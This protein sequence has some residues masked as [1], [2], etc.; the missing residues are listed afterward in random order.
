MHSAFFDVFVNLVCLITVICVGDRLL[1][2]KGLGLNLS[3]A[4]GIACAA[5]LFYFCAKVFHVS[6]YLSPFGRKVPWDRPN[7]FLIVF[8]LAAIVSL[9]LYVK[10]YVIGDRA[11]ITARMRSGGRHNK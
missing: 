10:N 3:A 7:I 9:V 1:Y 11:K 6:Y 5:L 2:A 8:G 4:I